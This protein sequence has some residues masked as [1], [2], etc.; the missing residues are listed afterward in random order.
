MILFFVVSLLEL[1]VF[2]SETP[3]NQ[4]TD[5]EK[6]EEINASFQWS[7]LPNLSN[8]AE[9]PEY[10]DRTPLQTQRYLNTL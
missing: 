3:S 2:V 4:S 6:A 8:I 10:L 1:H 9:Y 5:T 7:A